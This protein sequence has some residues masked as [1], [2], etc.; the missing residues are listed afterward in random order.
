MTHARLIRTNTLARFVLGIA[1]H[2]IILDECY[3]ALARAIDT[4]HMFVS[5]PPR[6]RDR[7]LLFSSLSKSLALTG[8]RVGSLPG[9]KVVISAV[10]ARQSRT[11]SIPNV[12]A[13]HALS[14]S[15]LATEGFAKSV[16]I[17]F[18]PIT[19]V[20]V[21]SKRLRTDEYT[22]LINGPLRLVE[23]RNGAGECG[24]H[25]PDRH[26]RRTGTLRPGGV[27]VAKTKTQGSR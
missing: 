24:G 18:W 19:V 9:P 23:G 21:M 2:C 4:Y 17:A 26:S 5:A 22:L 25:K 16:N 15:L 12:I 27:R 3:E 6:V 11:T 13:Q 10:K 7:N 1:D 14:R 20:L 8:M